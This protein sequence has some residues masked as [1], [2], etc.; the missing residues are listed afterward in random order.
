MVSFYDELKDRTNDFLLSCIGCGN[1]MKV[2]PISESSNM[3][4][5]NLNTA[6]SS[7]ENTPLPE[8]IIEFTH[9]C[10]QCGLC[11]DVCP[12]NS[13]REEMMLLLKSKLQS[14]LPKEYHNK[15]ALKGQN[16]GFVKNI[17]QKFAKNKDILGPLLPHYEKRNLKECDTLFYFGCYMLSPTEIQHNTIII[18]NKLGIDYEILGG[19]K[20]CCGMPHYYAGQIDNSEIM[21]IELLDAINKVNP[22]VVITS[23]A[24]CYEALKN[25]QRKMGASFQPMTTTEWI[26][27]NINNLQLKKLSDKVMFHESCIYKRKENMREHGPEVIRKVADLKEFQNIKSANLC[28]GNLR[29]DHDPEGLS[30][31]HDKKLQAAKTTGKMCVECVHCWENFADDASRHGI[32]LTDITTLV[33]NALID[34][35]EGLEQPKEARPKEI[36]EGE[37]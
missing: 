12:T 6:T 19:L 16:L 17:K 26:L 33:V 27:K 31:L 36:F 5:K 34:K 21:H 20:Y 7:P 2:C 32:T 18:A 24:E 25:L 10:F 4:I 14:T 1:C 13:H 9:K 35:S 37:N 29:C 3:V 23:C 28:C 15:L 30:T 11:N 8:S 22:K